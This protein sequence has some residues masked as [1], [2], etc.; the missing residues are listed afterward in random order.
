MRYADVS[1]DVLDGVSLF[2]RDIDDGIAGGVLVI[3]KA[4]QLAVEVHLNHSYPPP[5]SGKRPI[6]SP[7]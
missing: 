5:M 6:L 4:A 7:S 3:S 2:D 1:D